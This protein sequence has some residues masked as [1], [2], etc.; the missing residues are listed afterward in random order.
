M[1]NNLKLAAKMKPNALSLS[2][3][4]LC[5]ILCNASTVTKPTPDA[6]SKSV[7]EAKVTLALDGLTT[8]D[9]GVT[10]EL[11]PTS[12]SSTDSTRSVT[13]VSPVLPLR[14]T[15]EPTKKPTVSPK[16]PDPSVSPTTLKV[17][18]SSK[19]KISQQSATHA[20]QSPTRTP[21][22]PPDTAAPEKR[23]EV[24]SA[25]A[26]A[27]VTTT[28]TPTPPVQTRA[29]VL[30][31][32]WT[33]KATTSQ[34]KIPTPKQKPVTTP[35]K[36]NEPAVRKTAAAP[37]K[38]VVTTRAPLSDHQA[39]PTDGKKPEGTDK[40]HKDHGDHLASTAKPGSGTH[41]NDTGAP[42]NSNNS[43]FSK[44]LLPVVLGIV[45]AVL[46]ICFAYSIRACKKKD[47][48]RGH[49]KLMNNG[50]DHEMGGNL[51]RMKLLADSSEDEF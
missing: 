16:K 41:K 45:A 40:G 50:K 4:I 47:R 11:P 33:T 15:T 32:R 3:W 20:T 31:T 6:G 36:L 10:T 22:S 37:V 25:T 19:Q 13:T 38:S 49:M 46:I 21:T 27:Q 29:S 44:L 26:E 7:N 51:D 39:V 35:K 48:V 23:D 30:T 43:M 24:N 12:K 9:A 42:N 18:T 5:L 14:T 1:R 8:V 34:P 28:L 17:T 2:L